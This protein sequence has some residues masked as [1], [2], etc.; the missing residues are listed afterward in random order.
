[1]SVLVLPNSPSALAKATWDDVAPY[2]DELAARPLDAGDHGR[3]AARVVHP[4]RAGHRGGG[5]GHDRLHH[6]HR[7]CREG[8]RPPAVLDRGASAGGGAERGAGPA[9][10]GVRLLNPD[11]R[12][13]P[14]PVSDPDRDLPRRERPHLRRAG[15]AQRPLSADHRLDHGRVGRGGTTPAT[16]AAVPQELGP[17][18]SG[19]G[20][21]ARPPSP[22]SSAGAS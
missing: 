20:H 7:R 11:A 1:M 5:P 18:T 19:S 17:D 12:H 21:S 2:F 10:G 16:A 14:G 22:I 13:H 9:A 15:G 6:R 8:G 3:V 4:R